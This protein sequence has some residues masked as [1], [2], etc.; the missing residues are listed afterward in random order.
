MET[1]FEQ[2]TD[3]LVYRV[4]DELK[5][6]D[7]H[8]NLISPIVVEALESLQR[9]KC[10]TIVNTVSDAA[11]ETTLTSLDIRYIIIYV[12]LRYDGPDD[13]MDKALGTIL[14]QVRDQ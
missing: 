10:K 14:E 4:T 2:I 9:F 5:I 7:G 13:A 12:S 8:T 3:S 1:V 11:T 6:G